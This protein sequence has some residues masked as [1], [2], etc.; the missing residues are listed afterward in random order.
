MMTILSGSRMENCMPFSTALSTGFPKNGFY[1]MMRQD[2]QWGFVHKDT[3]EPV[4]DVWFDQVRPFNDGFATVCK[5]EKWTYMDMDG[6]LLGD[7]I[8]DEVADWSHGF[9]AARLKRTWRYMDKEGVLHGKY[10]RATQFKNGFAG[11]AIGKKHYFINSSF[12]KE[13]GPFDYASNILIGGTAI[14]RDAD[15]Q[16]VML[17]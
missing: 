13:H 4:G 11:V 2:N 15:G 5:N 6:K 14:V 7:L 8:F 10:S 1:T 16:R 3:M 9:G 17:L 12:E